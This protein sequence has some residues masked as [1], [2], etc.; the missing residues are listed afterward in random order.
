MVID[1]DSVTARAFSEPR[2][3]RVPI[4]LFFRSI[5]EARGD[6]IAIVLSGA[7]AD[8]AKGVRA[9]NEAG[10][11]IMVQEPTEA[12]FPSMPQNAIASGVADFVAPLAR[13]AERI[14][15]VARSK[16]AVRS[17]DLDSSAN[18]LR[19]I[20]AFLRARTGH[21]F[22]GYKR[23]TVM[24]RVI[25]R[26]QVSNTDTL[27]AYA[28]HLLIAPE[29]TKDLL[30]D[31]LISVTSF[32]RDPHAYE[33]LE[34]H[35]ITRLFDDLN[36]EREDPIR[37]WVV[38]C[39]TGEEAY[40][41]AMLL[42]EEADRR[43]M[44][45]QVQV[46]ATDL[47]ERALA[48]ARDARYP[49]SIEVN[50]AEERLARFFVDE[51]TH[52][53]IRKE[54]RE[55]VLFAS[56]SVIKEPPFLRLDLISCRNLLIYLERSLQQQLCSIFHSG[57]KPGCFLFLGSAET[58]DVAPD[59]FAPLDRDARIYC[60]R[61]HAARLLPVMPQFTIPEQ[62]AV[63]GLSLPAPSELTD[64]P[65]TLHVSAL[66]QNAPASVL[67]DD[68][69]HILHLSPSAG[70]F[71][72]HSVG[73]VSN[74]LPAVVR[75]ELRLDLRL[76]L[77]RAIEQRKPTLTHPAVVAFDGFRRH[78]AMHV[79]PVLG[80]A[81]VGA[82]A[83]VFFVEGDGVPDVEEP[84]TLPDTRSDEVRRLHA[85]LR[86]AQEAL[87][88]SRNG[89]DTAVQDLR[90]TNEELQS[91]NEE[92]R[93]TAEELETYKEETA[94]MVRGPLAWPSLGGVPSS[95]GKRWSLAMASNPL[96]A[97]ATRAGIGR[98]G[99]TY[100]GVARHHHGHRGPQAPARPATAARGRVAASDPQLTGR[101]AQRRHSIDRSFAWS[102][103]IRCAPFGA[104]PSAGLPVPLARLFGASGRR[105][106]S[107]AGRRR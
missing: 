58:A 9:V 54:L 24:R 87:S 3:H 42:H 37:A 93:S 75:P 33:A 104:R 55:C 90:A 44:H 63:P 102:G 66:E 1:G 78:V 73:P 77:T 22:S 99:G 34:R 50:V 92:Y 101:G 59:L 30:S 68:R 70:R 80:E 26:M 6:G 32:F 69:H 39:A 49:R 94:R 97:T 74:L 100:R 52:Y 88:A 83:L 105:G 7:G 35:V 86:A 28:D 107:G 11:V 41:L 31:L 2:W 103:R 21:D 36:A 64:L 65:G 27:A 106:G 82:R 10:G 89:H 15:E 14:V 17:L 40:S 51:G 48:T 20:V 45:P 43:K 38:G 4:D 23:A 60:A 57:L 5:A 84:E 56:H 81:N 67:V 96:R 19:R 71:I 47:D 29:E 61:P 95:A 85:E 62:L 76:A 18:D 91:I 98:N 12:G 16:E 72:L 25:R 46:F 13:L 8:G 53:R 79:A